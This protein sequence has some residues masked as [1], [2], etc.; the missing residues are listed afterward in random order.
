M[1]NHKTDTGAGCSQSTWKSG[2]TSVATTDVKMKEVTMRYETNAEV[3]KLV[4]AGLKCYRRGESAKKGKIFTIAVREG[5]VAE[6]TILWD[7]DKSPP[8]SYPFKISDLVIVFRLDDYVA[9]EA[10]AAHSKLCAS[11]TEKDDDNSS[12]ELVSN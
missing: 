9:A 8:S 10:K 11:T 2:K 7:G 4:T 6:C 1:S 5:R 3:Y 12:F